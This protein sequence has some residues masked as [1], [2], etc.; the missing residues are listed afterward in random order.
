MVSFEI[1]DDRIDA[2]KFI[3]NIEGIAFASTLGH[4]GTT[5]FHPGSS[6]HRYLDLSARKDLGISEGFFR[7]SVG[8]EDPGELV[9]SIERALKA[10]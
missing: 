1:G 9:V 5:V 4:V 6:S 10:I 7:V 3:V 2:N 8:L